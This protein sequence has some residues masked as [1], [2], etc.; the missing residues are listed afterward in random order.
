MIN[1][2]IWKNFDYWLLGGVIFLCLF[3]I[4]MIQSAIG[5]NT[6]LAGL[7]QRQ[8]IYF[9]VGLV[10][11]IIM[12]LID[13]HYWATF[14]RFLYIFAVV[15]LIVIFVVG[16]AGSWRPAGLPWTREPTSR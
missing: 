12:S 2:E 13:Y 11:I 16:S 14:M 5:G 15:A 8:S 7:P 6:L 3:G 1:K 4:I 10:V 9:A